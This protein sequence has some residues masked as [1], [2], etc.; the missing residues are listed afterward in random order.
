MRAHILYVCSSAQTLTQKLRQT[1]EF[2]RTRNLILGDSVR[3]DGRSTRSQVSDIVVIMAN[4]CH[5]GCLAPSDATRPAQRGKTLESCDYESLSVAA[6]MQC[7][8]NLVISVA[9]C[10]LSVRTSYIES[11]YRQQL[12]AERDSHISYR[13]REQTTHKLYFMTYFYAPISTI[14]S[15]VL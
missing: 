9:T 8:R 1:I 6:G 5:S 14:L 7:N 11:K 3:A 10:H 12:M 13:Q 4:I 2:R 15:G